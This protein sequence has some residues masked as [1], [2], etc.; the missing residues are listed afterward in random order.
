ML[1]RSK[2]RGLLSECRAGSSNF[3]WGGGGSKLWFKNDCWTYLRQITTW[4]CVSQSVNAGRRWRRSLRCKQ[5]RT[6]H[7]R[8][9]T[10]NCVHFWISLKFSLVSKC[11]ARFIKKKISRLKTDVRSCRCKNFSLKQA[12]GLIGGSG[13]L[14]PSPWIRHWNVIWIPPGF[15]LGLM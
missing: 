6:D 3:W 5:R 12:S 15:I 9:P 8:V 7:R 1:A 13:P 4:P 14:G 11:N 2:P 10:N